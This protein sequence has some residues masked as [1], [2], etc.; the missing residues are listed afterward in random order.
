MPNKVDATWKAV[1]RAA[2]LFLLGVLLQGKLLATSKWKLFRTH[3]AHMSTSKLLC[4]STYEVCFVTW[5]DLK[6][7][8]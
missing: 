3:I 6:N 2:K 5:L 4:F 7:K 8:G 1:V